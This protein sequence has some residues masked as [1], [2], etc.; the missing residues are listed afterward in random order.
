MNHTEII[1]TAMPREGHLAH[2][3][4]IFSYLKQHHNSRLVLDPTY[5]E[6][7]LDGFKKHNLKQFYGNVK[8]LIPSNAPRAIGK[9]FIIRAYVDANFAGDSLTR[10][11]RTGFIVFVNGSPIYWMSK[12]QS[13]LETSSF[14]SEFVAMR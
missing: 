5:P 14:G 12:K 4:Y 1:N 9:E 8:E 6:I 13:S 10:R 2:V 7:D 3:L 11:S